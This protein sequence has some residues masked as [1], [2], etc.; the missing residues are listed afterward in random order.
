MI[1][2]VRPSDSNIRK[3]EYKKLEKYQVLGEELDNIWRVK[4]TAVQVV[5]V[6][7]EAVTP[8]LGK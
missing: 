4:A 8:K 5:I 7:P 2:I 1:D 6:A 3:K